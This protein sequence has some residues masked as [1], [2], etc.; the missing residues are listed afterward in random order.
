MRLIA[1]S[2]ESELRVPLPKH[3]AQLVP[4]DGKAAELFLEILQLRGREC[5][6]FHARRS[7]F[8]PDLQESRQLIQS[9][10]DGKGMLHEP[11]AIGGLRRV[12]AIAVGGAPGVEKASAL[13]VTKRVRAE[14]AEKGKLRRPQVGVRIVILHK[15]G[16]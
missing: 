8:L 7:A 1:F 4:Q 5:A 12:L 3:F 2:C 16:I 11:N 9:E 10:P 13:I 15:Y 6:N 14:A